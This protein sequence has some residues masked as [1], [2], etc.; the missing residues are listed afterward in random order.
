MSFLSNASELY[1]ALGHAQSHGGGS[2]SE[3]DNSLFD[4]A[5]SML[6]DRKEHYGSD[7]DVDEE[8]LMRAHK[9]MYRK[10]GHHHDE[11]HDSSTVGEG[12]AMQ[13]LQMFT[14]GGDSDGGMDKNM[15]IGMAMSQAGTLWEEKNAQGSVVCS[16]SCFLS[17]SL[18]LFCWALLC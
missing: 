5:L 11:T 10:G 17:L 1:S 16:C 14:S 2:H 15:L 4:T 12:A 6:D 7:P 13:A 8:S 3:E 9:K 18:S